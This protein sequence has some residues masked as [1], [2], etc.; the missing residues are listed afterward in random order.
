MDPG[1]SPSFCLRGRGRTSIGLHQE[2]VKGGAD[3]GWQRV[4]HPSQGIGIGIGIRTGD[5]EPISMR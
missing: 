3:V 1:A 5:R 2:A 4:L